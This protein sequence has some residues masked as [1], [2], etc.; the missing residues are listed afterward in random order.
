MRRAAMA[1]RVAVL[2][3]FA[4]AGVGASAQGT[5]DGPDGIAFYAPPS[6]LPPGRHG[7][8]IWARPLRGPATL[9]HAAQN[10]LVLYRTTT[11]TGQDV[12]VSGT[13]A[14][15]HGTPPAEGWP[16]VSWAHGTTGSA[17]QCAPSRTDVPDDEQTALDAWVAHGY[18]VVQTDYEGEGVAGVHP[19]FVGGDA[20]HDVTDIV[21]A[22]RALVPA[23]G[24]RWWVFGHSE[25]G[26]AAIFTA[27]VGP[28]W[29]P[30]LHLMGAVALAPASHIAS[31]LQALP[32][33]DEPTTN[34]P[35][36]LEMIQGIASV[37]PSIRLADL[38]TP[39]AMQR[40]PDL[41]THCLDELMGDGPW[42]VLPPS[43]I[44]R[45][46][47]DLRPLLFDFAKN[48]DDFVHADV[49]L[50]I[51]QGDADTV[52][53]PRATAALAQELCAN[54]TPTTYRVLRGKTHATIVTDALPAMQA[55]VD[56]V[57]TGDAPHPCDPAQ[58]GK[59]Q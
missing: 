20:A 50:L 15:P 52:V 55:W 7:E 26:S 47:A 45:T 8:V 10:L 38:L 2:V 19:Y 30:E 12:A 29:A 9:P 49:P 27:A 1:L 28:R 22:A 43:H 59:N 4:S 11:V 58:F 24:R 31:E 25:G 6:P 17:P 21:R 16:V 51:L 56:A 36:L 35:L 42:L 3:A 32:T 54:G 53:M 33:L 5:A 18:A 39:P 40:L 41:Q 44:F 46:G 13:I 23:L 37:D 34:L 48:Q 57:A 14:V